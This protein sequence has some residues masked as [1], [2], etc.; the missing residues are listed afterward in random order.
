MDERCNMT[1]A[2]L[3]AGTCPWCGRTILNGRVAREEREEGGWIVRDIG[4]EMHEVA[5]L[6]RMVIDVGPL[7]YDRAARCIEE[8]AKQLI[9][10]HDSDQLHRNVQPGNIYLDDS[11][12]ARLAPSPTLL[13]VDESPQTTADEEN[14][15][16]TADYLAPEQ[17]LNSH[18]SDHRADIYSL[19]CTLYFLLTG[20]PP[21]PDG[22]ISERLLK[23]QTAMPESISKLRRDAPAGLIR[24][25]E[26][27]MAKKPIERYQSATEV[28]EAIAAWRNS[29]S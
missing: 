4:V 26:K 6:Q 23:H 17:A 1:H 13:E 14:V 9:G 19:G 7:E 10:L 12:T 11:G 21:F 24:I 22:S 16:G 28:V 3:L 18:E 20:R 15:L 29:A 27:M 8:L 25:C 5:S 2:K